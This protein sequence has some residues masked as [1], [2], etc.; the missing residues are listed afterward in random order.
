MLR[1]VEEEQARIAEN[2]KVLQ[3]MRVLKQKQ[4]QEAQKQKEI[5]DRVSIILEN[6]SMRRQAEE[7][8]HV[9]HAHPGQ[10]SKV[11]PAK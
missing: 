1:F 6:K 10:S 2:K 4:D 7:I 3:E 5:D 8:M 11:V 9:D